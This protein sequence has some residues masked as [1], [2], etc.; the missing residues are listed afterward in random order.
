[1]SHLNVRVM[2]T[3]RGCA[4]SDLPIGL[5]TYEAGDGWQH[6]AGDTTNDE[7]CTPELLGPKTILPVGTYR[8]T[9]D[10]GT[11]FAANGMDGLF[12][13]VRVVFEI[14]REGERFEICLQ[15]SQYG[16][17]TSLTSLTA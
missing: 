12:P 2:D 4:G 7:G 8:L 14:P 6:F 1:M 5:E 3:T 17:A 11:Y 10:T 9:F 16:Y 15:L 13:V